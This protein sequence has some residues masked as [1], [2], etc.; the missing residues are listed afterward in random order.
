MTDANLLQVRA[1]INQVSITARSWIH[2]QL[3]MHYLWMSQGCFQFSTA[4][5]YADTIAFIRLLEQ[6][7]IKIKQIETELIALNMNEAA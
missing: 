3:G 1:E 2:N 7:L 4:L 6:H 5:D